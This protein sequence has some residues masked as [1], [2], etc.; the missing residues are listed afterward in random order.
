MRGQVKERLLEAYAY[1]GESAP[2]KVEH[3]LDEALYYLDNDRE[4][5]LDIIE[6][7]EHYKKVPVDG[8]L[9]ESTPYA[10]ICEHTGNVQGHVY[11]IVNIEDIEDDLMCEYF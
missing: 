9:N 7:Y 6:E 1:F 8:E 2:E 3:L 10:F 5:Y 11:E 4:R